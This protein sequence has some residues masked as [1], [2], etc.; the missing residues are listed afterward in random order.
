MKHKKHL[1]TRSSI[2]STVHGCILLPIP[3]SVELIKSKNLL[4][5][6][7]SMLMFTIP[8]AQFSKKQ[9]VDITFSTEHVLIELRGF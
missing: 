1:M 4:K 2:H 9:F 3:W 8:Y 5:G 7:V 6:L